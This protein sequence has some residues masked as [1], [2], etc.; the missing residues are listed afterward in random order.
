[1]DPSFSAAFGPSI[2]ADRYGV[3]HGINK[4]FGELTVKDAHKK[5][6]YLKYGADKSPLPPCPSY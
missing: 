3:Q 1:M 4:Q 2:D 6:T 5:L